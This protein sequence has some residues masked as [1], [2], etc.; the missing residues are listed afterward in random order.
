MKKHR[1]LWIVIICIVAVI[2]FVL[3][4]F[5]ISVT[6][7]EDAESENESETEIMLDEANLV[8]FDTEK[9]LTIKM[10]ENIEEYKSGDHSVYYFSEE[11]MVSVKQVMFEE[12]EEAGTGDADTTLEEYIAIVEESNE[13]IQFSKDSY[14]NWSVTYSSESDD[15]KFAYYSTVRKGSEAFWLINFSCMEEDKE[16]LYPQFEFWANTIEVK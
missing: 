5:D 11:C 15:E 2:A 16:V 10:P 13:N 7:V 12:L 3:I 4:N 9:G 6:K 14:G 8:I 1:N